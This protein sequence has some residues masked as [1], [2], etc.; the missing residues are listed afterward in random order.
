[1]EEQLHQHTD[2]QAFADQIVDVLPKKLHE[3]DEND[4]EEG[5]HEVAHE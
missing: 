4:D 1:V 2:F 5:E 3:Q